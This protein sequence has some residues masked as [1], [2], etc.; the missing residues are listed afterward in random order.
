[1]HTDSE[2]AL[3]DRLSSYDALVEV[4]VGN[5]P[6]VAAALDERGC[7][8]TATDVDTCAVPGTVRF[9][10]DDVTDPD[11]SV[12]SGAGAVYALNCPPE[13]QRPL[14]SLASR[15]DADCLFTTLGGDPT[16]VDATPETLPT[17]T[18]YHYP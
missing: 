11:V 8:V 16:L 14:V 9:V 10:R 17:Q 3:V 4:G 12:Y 2:G 7:R 1:M 15:V 18:L 13:L 5:R 6:T